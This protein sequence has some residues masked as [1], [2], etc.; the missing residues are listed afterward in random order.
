MRGE[1]LGTSANPIHILPGHCG[2]IHDARGTKFF[3]RVDDEG[4]LQVRIPSGHSLQ[5]ESVNATF[6]LLIPQTPDP[7]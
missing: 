6:V 1:P 7:A 2:V 3:V 5:A 4:R